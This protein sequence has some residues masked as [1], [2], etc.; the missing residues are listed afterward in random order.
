MLED[1]CG[2]A[3]VSEVVHEEV[4]SDWDRDVLQAVYRVVEFDRSR[5]TCVPGR[6]GSHFAY[7]AYSAIGNLRLRTVALGCCG[8]RRQ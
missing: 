1:D 8:K 3:F 2:T 5:G 6:P 7:S 4:G